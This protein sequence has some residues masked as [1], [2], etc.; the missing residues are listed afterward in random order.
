MLGGS[1]VGLKDRVAKPIVKLIGWAIAHSI[2]WVIECAIEWAVKC[3]IGGVCS[4]LGHRDRPFG[5]DHGDFDEQAPNM[6]SA[7]AESCLELLH[8]I[9][10]I[11]PDRVFYH[12][13]EEAI[14]EG[15]HHI[16]ARRQVLHQIGRIGETDLFAPPIDV[17]SRRI[18][19]FGAFFGPDAADGIEP[20]QGETD[21]VDFCMTTLTRRFARLQ[22][23][24]FPSR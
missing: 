23:D 12:M 3:A 9:F 18:D 20:F 15:L 19:R 10:A 11:S 4:S 24:P 22:R 14:D 5:G 7:F 1:G 21:P 17:N 16:I 6:I 13:Q 8:P 2:E